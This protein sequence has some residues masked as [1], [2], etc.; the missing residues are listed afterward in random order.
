MDGLVGNE[1]DSDEESF[2]AGIGSGSGT[3]ADS[4]ASVGVQDEVDSVDAAVAPPSVGWAEQMVLDIGLQIEQE[5]E[6]AAV[7]IQAIHR[8]KVARNTLKHT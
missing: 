6:Q 2:G 4:E 5:E 7:R 8:G 3:A 1:E